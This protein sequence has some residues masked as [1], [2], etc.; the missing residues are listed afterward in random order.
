MLDLQGTLGKR[1]AVTADDG[2]DKIVG[3]GL[4]RSDAQCTTLTSR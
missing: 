3:R 2:E 4:V 1:A